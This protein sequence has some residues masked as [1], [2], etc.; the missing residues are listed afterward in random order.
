MRNILIIA[1]ASLA[2]IG[3][4]VS[5]AVAAGFSGSDNPSSNP[6]SDCASAHG[7]AT[8]AGASLPAAAECP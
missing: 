7:V 3:G 4:S 5:T 1:V 2:L 8:A 6:P